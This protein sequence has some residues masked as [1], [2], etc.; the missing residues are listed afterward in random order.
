LQ[1]KF[2]ASEGSC[3]EEVD[4]AEDC[5]QW[6]GHQEDGS[7]LEKENI[8]KL[9]KDSGAEI[10]PGEREVGGSMDLPQ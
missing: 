10:E 2:P 9:F 5:S 7:S 1:S 4:E 3:A 8:S 6:E